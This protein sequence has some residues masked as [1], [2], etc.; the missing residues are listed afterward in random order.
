MPIL[1]NISKYLDGHVTFGAPRHDGV[2]SSRAKRGDPGILKALPLAIFLC[3]INVLHAQTYPV[4]KLLLETY[5]VHDLAEKPAFQGGYINFGY[6]KNIPLGK[7]ITTEE[8]IKASQALYELV[9]EHLNIQ[10]EDS[11]VEVGCGRGNG[12]V[13]LAEKYHP[14]SVTGVD[15]I[16]QQINRAKRIHKKSIKRHAP[17][18]SFQ[19]GSSSSLPFPDNS[20]T[21]VFSVEAAQCFPSMKDFAGEAWRVLQPG[22]R[23]VVTAHF[24]TSEEGYQALRKL[25]PTVDQGVDLLIP[26]E[27][28]RSAFQKVGFKEVSFQ[29]IGGD[30][31]DGLQKW[32]LNVQDVKWAENYFVSYKKGFLDYYLI[33]LEK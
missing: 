13:A 14:V 10:K 16:P 33:I 29:A 23:L 11:I 21:K 18:L 25:I 2:S 8:R 32:R 27:Q 9:F 1:K 28:V 19:T 3:L 12:C 6:W 26:I 7:T 22:G 31:F 17:S 5:G 20:Q 15:I 30:V 4:N 24:A